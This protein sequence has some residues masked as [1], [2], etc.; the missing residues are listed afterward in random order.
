MAYIYALDQSTTKVGY[1]LWE[2]GKIIQTGSFE[3][4][5]KKYLDI[6]INEIF[7]WFANSL[8]VISADGEKIH[9]V[10]EDIQLQTK[11]NGSSKYFDNN[12]SNVLTFKALA[13]LLSVLKNCCVEKEIEYS[14]LTPSQW[15]S[16]V[17]IKNKYRREQKLETIEFVLN[18]FDLVVGEDEADAIGIGYAYIKRAQ[19]N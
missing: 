8:D 13:G 6:R 1:S 2:D 15:K 11:I 19:E 10:F 12:E 14:I 18:K 3:P 5:N 7:S 16:T 9:V 4:A 17:G